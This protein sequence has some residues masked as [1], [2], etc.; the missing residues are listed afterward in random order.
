[1]SRE[2][3]SSPLCG[4]ESPRSRRVFIAMLRG[5]TWL[6]SLCLMAATAGAADGEAQPRQR[7][8]FVM[9][10]DGTQVRRVVYIESYPQLGSPRSRTT[11]GGWPSRPVGIG[12]AGR[13]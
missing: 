2:A 12:P 7:A 8:I 9:H 11:A 10:P 1:M 13:Y 4:T 3:T 6:L 5:L